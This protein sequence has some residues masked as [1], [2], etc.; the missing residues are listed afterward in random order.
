[1][2]MDFNALMPY[3]ITDKNINVRG[4][5]NYGIYGENILFDEGKGNASV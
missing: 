2:A 5:D 4:N 1:M 3:E